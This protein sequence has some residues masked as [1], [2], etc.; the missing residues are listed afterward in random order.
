[1]STATSTDGT[2]ADRASLT[3]EAILN[4]AERLFAEHGRAG[5]LA[6]WLHH[7][8]VG[9]AADLIPTLTKTEKLP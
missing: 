3:R 7:R 6:A 5:F 1:M 2:R 9:W 4:A 8:D